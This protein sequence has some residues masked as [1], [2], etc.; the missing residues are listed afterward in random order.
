MNY[1]SFI[2]CNPIINVTAVSWFITQVLKVLIVLLTEK[3]ID[4]ERFVGAG[5][6]PSSHSSTVC[7]LSVLIGRKLG[8]YSPEFA[9]AFVFSLVIM[10]DAAGVRRAAGQQASVLNKMLD[11][12][13]TSDHEFAEIELKELLGH[14]PL[15]VIMGAI[16]GIFIG[17]FAVI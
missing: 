17:V 7:T 12:W 4:F 2:T 10:Y 13:Y 5:G 11:N 9:I 16:I 1:L 15:Q 3:R 14:T 6:M 8:F